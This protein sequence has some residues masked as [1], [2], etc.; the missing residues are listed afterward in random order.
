MQLGYISV[1]TRLEHLLVNQVGIMAHLLVCVISSF[2]LIVVNFIYLAHQYANFWPF[3]QNW[4]Q[5][6]GA[7]SCRW[8]VW[9]LK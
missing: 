3:I 2:N 1:M 5:M 6:N 7:K 9:G 8:S 4:K